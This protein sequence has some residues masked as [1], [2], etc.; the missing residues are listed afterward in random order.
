METSLKGNKIANTATKAAEK[1]NSKFEQRRPQRS[2]KNS[3]M[4]AIVE[5]LRHTATM[6]TTAYGY[7]WSK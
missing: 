7:E 4:A 2:N 6:M 3:K 5:Q 1:Q